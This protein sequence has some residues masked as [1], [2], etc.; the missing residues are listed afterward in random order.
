MKEGLSFAH[1]P[2]MFAPVSTSLHLYQIDLFSPS[3]HFRN[4]PE[5]G[6]G[7]AR[8]PWGLGRSVSFNL[9]ILLLFPLISIMI[10]VNQEQRNHAINSKDENIA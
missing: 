8:G 4:L 7:W 10:Q 2:S 3:L 1:D 6:G 5:E 9:K